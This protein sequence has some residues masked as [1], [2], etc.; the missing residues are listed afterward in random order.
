MFS[1][2]IFL[3]PGKYWSCSIIGS[4]LKKREEQITFLSE[5]RRDLYGLRNLKYLR[6]KDVDVINTQALLQ[7]LKFLFVVA[8]NIAAGRTCYQSS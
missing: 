1:S 2:M 4:V 6:D 3:S 8:D 7:K 5:V